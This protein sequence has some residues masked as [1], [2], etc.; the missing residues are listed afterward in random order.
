MNKSNDT[1]FPQR[2][3]G[4]LKSWMLSLY[5]HKCL[6]C[7]CLS[8]AWRVTLAQL[9]GKPMSPLKP[10]MPNVLCVR[11][12]ISV[13]ER[14]HPQM[15]KKWEG[16]RKENKCGTAGTVIAMLGMGMIDVARERIGGSE[17]RSLVSLCTHWNNMS[18][19]TPAPET[20]ILRD[21]GRVPLH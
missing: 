2:Q 16:K 5:A 4:H 1:L 17:E 3:V 19:P 8:C 11:A 15:K 7:T 21:F 18:S 12:N 6:L 20:R 14:D 9:C 10:L 13:R